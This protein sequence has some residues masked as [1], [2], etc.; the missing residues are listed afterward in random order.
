[1]DKRSSDVVVVGGGLAGLAAAGLVAR[2]GRTVSVL[3]GRNRLGGRAATDRKDGYW[4]NQG[5]HALYRGGAGEA[6]LNELG[7]PLRGGRP[8]TRG[9][10]VVDGRLRL[11]PAGPL[12]LLRSGAVSPREKVELARLLATLPKSRP[13]RRRRADGRGVGRPVGARTPG[14]GSSFTGWCDWRRT[15]TIRGGSAPRSRSAS[16]VPRSAPG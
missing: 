13:G 7:V 15:S 1:M 8:P 5:P 4:L 11:A 10:V 14:A 6:V 2:A 9:S 3:E 12:S 16:S